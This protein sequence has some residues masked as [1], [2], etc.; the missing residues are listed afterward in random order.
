[1]KYLKTYNEIIES[2]LINTAILIQNEEENFEV[3]E[4][5]ISIGMKY[6]GEDFTEPVKIDDIQI[7]RTVIESQ[8]FIIVYP[9]ENMYKFSY[10]EYMSGDWADNT[11]R[12]LEELKFKLESNK[13]GLL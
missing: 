10:G 5:L 9:P 1:M 13:M 8:L 7:N 2:K 6:L 11:S 3:Q 4:Y 12:N